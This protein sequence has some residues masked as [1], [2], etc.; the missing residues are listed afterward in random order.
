MNSEEFR[1]QFSALLSDGMTVAQVLA[2]LDA[3][4]SGFIIRRKDPDEVPAILMEPLDAFISA[5]NVENKSVKTLSLYRSVISRFLLSVMK[6]V[7]R[8]TVTDIRDYLSSCKQK[9]NAQS[10]VCNTRR[11]LNGFFEWLV[12]EQLVPLNPVRR[13]S[14]IRQEKSP[15]HAMSLIELEYLRNACADLRE[16]A[17]VDFLYSTGARVSEL[18]SVRITDIDWDRKE[19]FIDHGKGNVSRITYLNPEAEVSLRAYLASRSDQSPFVFARSRGVSSSP[20][21]ARTVQNTINRI[22]ARS[23]RTFSVRITPHVFRH[24]IATVM[25]RNGTPVEQVQRFLGHSNINTT[26]IYAEIRDEDVRRSHALHA[27]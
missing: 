20:L 15:R 17:L 4:S 24:T 27:S 22:V 3:V 13:V 25:L 12:L 6:P 1:T 2:A 5:K 21:E 9:G 11:I 14:S 8:I 7:D 26:M 18:C 19:V 16:K 10:T 23:G